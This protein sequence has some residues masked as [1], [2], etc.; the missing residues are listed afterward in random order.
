MDIQARIPLGLIAVHNF[1]LEYDDCDLQH[2]LEM[3]ELGT[4]PSSQTEPPPPEVFGQGS[5]PRSEYARAIAHRDQIA[6]EMWEQYQQFLQD[7]PDVLHQV[8]DP[9]EI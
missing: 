8:F 2:Y 3:P 6:G 9:E 5:I 1:I 7:H 4:F